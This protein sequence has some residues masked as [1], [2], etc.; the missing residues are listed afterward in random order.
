MAEVDSSVLFT[1]EAMGAVRGFLYIQF[2]QKHAMYSGTTQRRLL[3]SPLVSL[4][5]Q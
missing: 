5:L 4:S 3:S 1:I 2:P